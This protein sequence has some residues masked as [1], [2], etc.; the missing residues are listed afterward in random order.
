MKT[1]NKL[2]ELLQEIEN[3]EDFGEYT[4]TELEK[5]AE[6]A[7][8]T[9]KKYKPESESINELKESIKLSD[10]FHKERSHKNVDNIMDVLRSTKFAIE[11]FLYKEFDTDF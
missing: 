11:S 6:K 9:I 2:I 8:K 3:K 7:I 10:I 1:E 4:M 5:I